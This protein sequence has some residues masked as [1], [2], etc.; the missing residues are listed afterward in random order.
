MGQEGSIATALC[1]NLELMSSILMNNDITPG[2]G[3]AAEEPLGSHRI[4]CAVTPA[5]MPRV[6]P[7][8]RVAT[9]GCTGPIRG[10]DQPGGSAAAPVTIPG[11]RDEP[12]GDA[13]LSVL[14]EGFLRGEGTPSL[15]WGGERSPGGGQKSPGEEGQ[16][17]RER[18][19]SP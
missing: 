4:G 15:V 13:I 9:G 19:Q 8:P 16:G 1:V 18:K 6:G 14:C 7:Y 10:R 3:V 2:Q 17:H 11:W 12:P 5:M